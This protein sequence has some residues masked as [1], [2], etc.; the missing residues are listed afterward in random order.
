MTKETISLWLKKTFFLI[1]TI[2]L[3]TIPCISYVLFEY[4][5]GNLSTIPTHMALLNIG[6]IYI[7]YLLIYAITGS[8]RI[9]IP[10]VSIFLFLLSVAEAFVVSFRSRPIMIWDVLA[11][12]TALTVSENYIFT[13]T[14]EMMTAGLVLL[15]ILLAALLFPRRIRGRKFRLAFA[16]TSA[17]VIAGFTVWFFSF[18][19]PSWQLGIN[20]WEV[21]ETYTEYG[22]ILST[23]VS[24]Q[25]VVK[26]KPSGYSTAQMKRIYDS[27]RGDTVDLVSG[28]DVSLGD[29]ATT[30]VNIICIMNESLSD[31]KTA[32]F[33]E[34]NQEYFPFLNS[35]TE[36][37]IKGSLAVPVF[38]SM[39]C[40]SEFEFLTGDSMALLPANSSA[41]QLYVKP[42]AYSLVST[43]KEQ[44]F[45][46]VAMHPF[47]RENWNRDT[48]YENMGFDDFIDYDGYENT[49]ILRNYISDQA[50]Y[51]K[52]IEQV[53]NKD[54]PSDRLFLFNV[55]MQNHGG[56]EGTYDNF[57]Q[58]IWLTGPLKGKYPRTDQYLSLMKR[59]DEALEYLIRYFEAIDE[60]TMIVMFG[61]HQP[62]VEDE[63][64]DEIAGIAS[65][66]VPAA[67]RL[68]WYETP[69]LIWT[70]YTSTSEDKG[71]MSA[72]Y[73]AAE[74]L[75]QSGLEM[76]PYHEFLLSMEEVLPVVHPLGCYDTD[77]TYYSWDEAM[78]ADFPY[79]DVISDY[80]YLVYNHSFDSKK[81]KDMYI[82]GSVAADS[83]EVSTDISVS[84]E[85]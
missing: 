65:S 85:Q 59:S 40:N 30:P 61:D 10:V 14:Y 81:Y 29:E 62:G 5:T 21:S 84:M 13:V 56:Y 45:R 64:Y 71:R 17:G 36:N 48:C 47:I 78:S 68:M 74:L 6:W 11:L 3:L 49:E 44:G 70:N 69:F 52:L 8:S 63:F 32:G 58:E 79:R 16:G 27:F 51:E 35:L 24:C 22:Y 33:F 23:A 42:E 46:A 31:L 66:D 72:V 1:I 75:Q 28:A 55:T 39:T 4:V 2:F 60:P 53:E 80:E 9:T 19:M 12:Q 67:D 26:K 54:N 83:S 18:L 20:M 41:Y 38:G 7:F 50:D 82:T 43:L 57:N 37:T 76:T 77:G 25:Y 73:L 15:H 34:T